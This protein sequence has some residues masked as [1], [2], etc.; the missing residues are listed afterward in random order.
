MEKSCK[1]LALDGNSL[2]SRAFYGIRPLSTR[3]GQPTN[4]VYGFLL[5]LFKLLEEERPDGLCVVFDRREPTFRHREY[6]EYKAQRRPTPP[7]LTAQLRAAH[8]G[9]AKNAGLDM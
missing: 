3:T 7:E 6:P 1:L 5:I 9:G 2:L 8:H 4:G